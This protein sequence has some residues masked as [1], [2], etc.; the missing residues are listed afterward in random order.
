MENIRTENIIASYFSTHPE[1]TATTREIFRFR[2][3]LRMVFEKMEVT[4]YLEFTNAS[5]IN[6]LNDY[7]TIFEWDTKQIHCKD[8]TR[9]EQYAKDLLNVRIPDKIREQYKEAI[10]QVL[11]IEKGLSIGEKFLGD[12]N[13]N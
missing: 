1:T 11:N 6:V 13:Y 8:K 3:D 12:L 4:V 2:E 5:L 9:L 7:P 10:K